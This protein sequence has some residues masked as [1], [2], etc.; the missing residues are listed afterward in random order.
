MNKQ[1][2]TNLQPNKKNSTMSRWAKLFS[3][4]ETIYIMIYVWKLFRTDLAN[5]WTTGNKTTSVHWLLKL[6][7]HTTA[8]ENCRLKSL[9]GLFCMLT[10]ES[11]WGLP[12]TRDTERS[13]TL[14]HLYLQLSSFV[15]RTSRNNMWF[16]KKCWSLWILTSRFCSYFCCIFFK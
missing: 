16:F 3:T 15:S 7:G 6:T 5:P 11:C 9:A 1:R 2:I 8:N 10:E 12:S 13:C 14:K 4:L